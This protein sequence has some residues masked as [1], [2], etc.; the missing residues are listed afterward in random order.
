[1]LA[2]STAAVLSRP[3]GASAQDKSPRGRI[4]D[5][6]AHWYPPE[7]V[8][9]M[10]REGDANGARMSRNQRGNVTAAIPNLSVSFQPQYIDIA[11]RIAAMDKAGVAMHALSLTQPMAFWAPPAFGLKLCQTF[12][13]ACVAV[14]KQHPD[15]FV[16][17]AM[18][19]MQ[20]PALAVQEFDRVAKLP[21]IR[22][23]YMA[24]HINGRNL[25]QKDFWPVYARCEERGFPILLHPVNPVGADRMGSYH[26]RNFIGNPTDTAIAAASLIFGG[27]LDAH[28]KLDVVLP[29]AGGVVPILIGRWDHGATV[30]PEVK[31]LKHPPSHYLRRFHYDTV[32]HSAPILMNIARQVGA[33]RIVAGTDFPADM[34]DVDPVRTIESLTELSA[35]DRELILR[36]NAARLLKLDA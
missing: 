14:H 35:A 4:I 32:A 26:L 7:W 8:A 17:L 20:D 5:V 16:G 31:D 11:T 36:G 28:P 6:H 15:R 25:D 3:I 23:I 1:F 33:D 21:G 13:D 12:N 29:H 19:P 27:A 34:S 10:E 24:T 22:G 18:L 9:L 2:G 30:R